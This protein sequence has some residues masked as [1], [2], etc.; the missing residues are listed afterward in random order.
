MKKISVVLA[1]DDKLIL[2]DLKSLINWENLGFQLVETALNGRQALKALKKYRPA[3]LVTDII[4]PGM[5]G[6]ELITRAKE[7]LPNLKIL[8]ITSYDDFGYAKRALQLGVSD[9]ILKNEITS[10]SLGGKL[11][12]IAATIE[13]SS[14]ISESFLRHEL[15]EYFK[16]TEQDSALPGD[17]S[18]LKND[19]YYFF[20]AAQCTP[21]TLNMDQANYALNSSL[22]YLSSVL[23]Q[24]TNISIPIQFFCDK[25][26]LFAIRMETSAQE[27]HF[28]LSS[29]TRQ[30]WQRF[31]STFNQPCILFYYPHRSSIEKIRKIYQ[32]ALPLLRYSSAMFCETQ[33]VD[34]EILLAKEKYVPLGRSFSFHQL[35][36]SKDQAEEQ[37]LK[38]RH[39]L[40]LCSQNRDIA[41]VVDFYRG[42]CI[43]MENL[44]Y[45]HFD[46]N[47]LRYFY[48]FESFLKWVF[49]T[50]QD[51]ITIK[52][53][54]MSKQLSPSVRTAIEYMQ[55]NYSDYAL[56]AEIISN[57]AHLSASRLGVLFK[58]ETNRTINEY[59][60]ELRINKAIYF[61]KNTNM[62]IYEISEK[63][64]YRS[65]QYFSQVF[66]GHTGKRPIDFR[67]V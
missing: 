34:L 63:C 66:C 47:E 46:P 22:E 39:Y 32:S 45:G 48:N 14:R 25:F 50:Y 24:F 23:E 36:G 41:S 56:T 2:N 61:L 58:Q 1:D 64:G 67:K 60:T 26:L 33:P 31:N 28:L 37:I 11:L 21:F 49:N 20:I 65:S 15:S 18:S 52:N 16:K 57:A 44:S 5:D 51:C 59:L 35:T 54:D 4:M 42:F 13:R 30:L 17:L 12:D 40:M 38:L 10:I 3:I 7:L 53:S 6:L 19:N 8:I 29:V 9:Y 55:E 27:R 62:K 43:Q